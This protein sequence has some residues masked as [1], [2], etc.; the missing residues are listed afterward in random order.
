MLGMWTA[1]GEPSA[2]CTENAYLNSRGQTNDSLIDVLSLVQK[3]IHAGLDS[4]VVGVLPTQIGHQ[5][6]QAMIVAIICCILQ[7]A[8]DLRVDGT[9]DQGKLLM[10]GVAASILTYQCHQ[11]SLRQ[12]AVKHRP[13]QQVS[14]KL[15]SNMC[16]GIIASQSYTKLTMQR[17]TA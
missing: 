3:T 10:L 9:L 15:C 7:P 8:A 17:S 1:K 16:A 11:C 5:V 12:S 2:A 13:A 14:T 6:R 4:S